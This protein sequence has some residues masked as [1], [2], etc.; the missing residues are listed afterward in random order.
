[1]VICRRHHIWEVIDNMILSFDATADDLGIKSL[2]QS[3]S[4]SVYCMFISAIM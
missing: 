1:M 3:D 2:E 4:H